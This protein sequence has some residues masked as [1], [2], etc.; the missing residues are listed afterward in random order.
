MSLFGQFPF[1]PGD[2]AYM[3]FASILSLLLIPVALLG[4]AIPYAVLYVKDRRN[5]EHDA[6]IGLKSALYYMLSLSILLILTG[7]TIL[8]IDFLVED[9]RA[10]APTPRPSSEFSPV[11][12]TAFALMVSGFAI[13]LFHLV[14]I[15]GFTNDRR[16]PATRRVFV[17]WRLAICSLVVLVSFTVLV[18]QVFQKDVRWEDLK[19]VFG[20]LLVWGPAWLIH[21]LLMRFYGSNPVG[22]RLRRS[23]IED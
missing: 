21:L 13:G 1:G 14:V 4:L 5:E 9:K 3:G 12:R 22:G 10:P 16:Y 18:V 15:L 17:G 19:P 2:L 8:V 11:Q 6:E 7:L 23:A 20:T